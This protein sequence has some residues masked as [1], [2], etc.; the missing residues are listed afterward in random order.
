[1]MPHRPDIEVTTSGFVG[2]GEGLHRLALPGVTGV[3]GDSSTLAAM[4]GLV[5]S[6]FGC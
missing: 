3:S 2:H 6:C 1:M 4:A 5:G